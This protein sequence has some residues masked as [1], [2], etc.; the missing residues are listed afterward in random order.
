[1]VKLLNAGK[2]EI[3]RKMVPELIVRNSVKNLFT[4]NR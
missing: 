2:L 1:M 4:G 3:C